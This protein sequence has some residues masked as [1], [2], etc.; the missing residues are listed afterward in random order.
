MIEMRERRRNA[1]RRSLDMSLERIVSEVI[2]NTMFV[3]AMHRIPVAYFV[4]D[5]CAG[6]GG[7]Q[8]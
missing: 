8:H 3:K 4:D 7:A 1:R 6:E 5:R 2:S